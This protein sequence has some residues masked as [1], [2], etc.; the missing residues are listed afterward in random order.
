VLEVSKSYRPAAIVFGLLV[1]CSFITGCALVPG[2]EVII[3]Y[4]RV[5]GIAGF[6]EALEIR[7]DRSAELV[8]YGNMIEF[9]LERDRYEYLIGLFE[10]AD[11]LHLDGD[12]LPDS[13]CCD[14]FG[15]TILYRGHTLHTMTGAIP[16]AIEPIL[17][18]L[19]GIVSEQQA[20]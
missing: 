13:T 6:N 2:D 7:E 10:T 20:N 15:Y 11:F 8:T 17:A 12:Y 4:R 5:G 16:V 1:A 3:E 14:L 18:A 9:Q 19:D